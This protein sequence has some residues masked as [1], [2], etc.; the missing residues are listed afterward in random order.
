VAE[1]F[2]PHYHVD[3]ATGKRVSSRFL[4]AVRK[5][6]KTWHIRYYTPDGVRHKV[7]GYR[8]KKATENK[9]AELER[10]G[11]RLD[12][13]IVDPSDVHAKTPLGEHL[14]DYL[15]Y[16]T[17]KGNTGK[18]VAL[19]ETRV[20][21]CLDAC[22]FIKIGDMQPAVVVSFLAD[23]RRPMKDAAGNEGPGKSIATA[24]YYLTAIKGFTRWLAGLGRRATMDPLAG[25]AKLANAAA[26]VRHSRRDLSAEELHWL[27]EMT[28][29]SARSYRRL[30][31]RDRFHL[32]LTA[33]ASGLRVAE[34]AS[35]TPV[36]FC[37]DQCPPVVRAEA[38]YTKNRKEAEQPLQPDVAEALR[39]YLVGRPDSSPIWPGT[40]TGK[41]A[42][43]LRRDLAEARYKWL[44]SFKDG[45]QR[46]EAEKGD[47]LVY[48][49]SAG[50]YADFHGA[51]RHTYISRIV[52]GGATPKVAQ[53][54]ARHS[55]IRLTL[56]RYAHAALHDVAAAVNGLPA[57]V[58]ALDP[59]SANVD[60]LRATGTDNLTQLNSPTHRSA[61]Q[62]KPI[63]LGPNLGPRPA[64][65][66]DFERQTETEER[67]SAGA[68]DAEKTAVLAAF[69]GEN[70]ERPLPDSNR[71]WRIC[72]PL[73]YRLAKGPKA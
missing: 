72:N 26:D 42:A 34:L 7:A 27:L 47:F 59:S 17:D 64:T 71:G 22:R 66:G 4:G 58:P 49:D 20:R 35:L 73:P 61:R 23:L 14:A 60:A 43:M 63:S 13:G 15:K 62:S 45:R 44:E 40:W 46:E 28:R 50:R 55:D 39:G 29:A 16:L 37:L 31:G 70:E 36:C 38:G 57:I 68:L 3:P 12:A 65:S 18:Y 54:L 19:T 11:I 10:R 48:C 67:D 51:T 30:S 56:G 69:A 33:A 52:Q 8:D 9:A 24:N 5:K 41:A 1:V 6:S 25:M 32:Y 2:R 21:A 53:E